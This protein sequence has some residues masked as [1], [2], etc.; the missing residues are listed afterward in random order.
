MEVYL[1][2]PVTPVPTAGTAACKALL[3]GRCTARSGAFFV[4]FHR[5]LSI[6]GL[7]HT[8]PNTDKDSANP[9]YKAPHYLQPRLPRAPHSFLATPDSF[10]QAILHDPTTVTII[11]RC[12]QRCASSLR[13]IPSWEAVRVDTTNLSFWELK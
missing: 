11:G 7:M 12:E 6:I 9:V 10:I 2:T 4:R 8:G 1:P 3:A 13:S 5:H